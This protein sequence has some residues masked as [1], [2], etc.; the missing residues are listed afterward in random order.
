[1]GERA[2]VTGAAGFIG[3]HLVERLVRE[4]CTVRAFVH[5]NAL[6]N[7]AHLQA[8]PRDVRDNVEVVPGDLADAFMVDRAVQGSSVVFHLGALIGIPYSYL[9]PA[10]YVSTNVVGTLNVLEACRRHD[11]RR[12][13]H[14]STSEVYGTA[15]YVPI[16]ERHPVVGQSPYSAT[17][18]AADQLAESFWRSFATPIVIVRPFNTY[19]PRQSA[20]AVI[21]TI[22][23]Q[24]LSG[25]DLKLG[26][27]DTV[28]DLTYVDDT[29]AGFLA[30]S[31]A[32]HVEGE[33][34]NLGTG[35]AV[36]IA[37][38]VSRVETILGRP[39]QLV[40]D[41]A[42]VRPAASEVG[43]LVSDNTK[44]RQLLSW[45]PS[46][47]LD[48]GLKRTF[49]AIALTLDDYPSDRYIV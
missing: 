15:Q 5:Y 12:L 19:G 30:A 49:D 31:R 13:L 46:I 4:G 43:R 20:R 28:R 8:L 25:G 11:V 36:T 22:I 21:P 26:S 44:A 27:T 7:W 23:T 39:L 6:N 3:S 48:E 45:T 41:A 18:I 42:R 9:A 37:A 16:D 34:I 38:L 14:T 33:T 24:A 1:M 10:A 32:T 35:E 40:R 47:T 17:K 29:V 2:L